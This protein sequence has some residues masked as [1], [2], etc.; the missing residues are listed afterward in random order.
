MGMGDLLQHAPGAG[1]DV[2]TSYKVWVLVI[3][4]YSLRAKG[5]NII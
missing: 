4:S 3:F 1:V 5:A 2:G